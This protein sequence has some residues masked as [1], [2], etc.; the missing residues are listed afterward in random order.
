MNNVPPILTA[1]DAEALA[2][3]CYFDHAK[4]EKALAWIAWNFAVKLYKWQW[5]ILYQYF[6]WRRPDGGYRFTNLH[7]WLP[8]KNGKSLLASII[9][10][11]KLFELKHKRIYSGAYCAKQAKLVMQG[12]VDCCKRSPTLAKLMKRRTGKLRATC[13][14]FRRTFLNDLTGCSYFALADGVNSNDGIISDVLIVDEIG[15]MKNRQIDV[16]M[17]STDKIVDALTVIISTAGTGDKEHRSWGIY[18]ADKKILSGEVIDTTTLAVIHEYPH[19]ELLKGE[20]IYSLDVVVAANPV[21]QEDAAKR[22]LAKVKCEEN[23]R[24]RRDNWWRRFQLGQWIQDDGDPYIATDLHDACEVPEEPDLI[25]AG[26]Y[27]GFDRTGGMWDLTAI[28]SSPPTESRR[29]KRKTKDHISP[30]L[31]PGN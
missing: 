10:G 6:G 12:L 25:G 2:Q 11:Y 19:P 16:L 17:G 15:L 20:E 29:W 18:Q 4:A 9:A 31:T 22:E 14:D 3:G 27:V 23:R 7:V 8:K 21:L 5:E 24:L 26:V 1:S 30:P 28:V 13:D